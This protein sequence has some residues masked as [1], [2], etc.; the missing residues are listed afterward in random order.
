MLKTIFNAINKGLHEGLD[1]Q[2]IDDIQ[3]SKKS[4][5]TDALIGKHYEYDV[6]ELIDNQ[7][8][9]EAA[10]FCTKHNIRYK[11]SDNK[12]LKK[13]VRSYIYEVKKQH[14]RTL[15]VYVRQCNYASAVDIDLNWIFI[16]NIDDVHDLFSYQNSIK[17][18]DMSLW[19]M[20]NVI[21]LSGWFSGCDCLR[22]V[23]FGFNMH[24][25]K[26]M[27][28][29]FDGCSSLEMV[30]FSN[31]GLSQVVSIWNCFNGCTS[32]CQVNFGN[33]DTSKVE[34]FN[35]MF[36][37]CFKITKLD[38]T[39]LDTSNAKL[40][41]QM[42]CDCVNLQSLDIST[43]HFNYKVEK[44]AVYQMFLNCKKLTDLRIADDFFV[45]MPVSL[46]PKNMFFGV[47][48]NSIPTWYKDI[49]TSR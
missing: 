6:Q 38:L 39:S 29:L 26:Y 5:N 34:N 45:H 46:S 20:S 24:N 25:V 49:K 12:L 35:C 28:N 21:S 44:M 19:D 40:F 22:T 37:N 47:P 10:N 11:I 16:S 31:T 1:F 43:W 14:D 2:D 15:D 17:S 30:D 4:L 41:T 8:Y 9:L 27:N 42:F 13:I 33:I 36:K 18:I 48:K 7:Q 32:L 3:V 23:K